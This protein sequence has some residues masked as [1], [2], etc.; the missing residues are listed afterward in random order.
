MNAKEAIIKLL[1]EKK[2]ENIELIDLK[3]SVY[4]VESVIVATI[5]SS[6]QA[7][8]IIDE[9]KEL[10]RTLGE[11]VL[12]EE[13]ADE[14]SV[15]DLGDCLIHLMS[16]LYRDKYQLEKFLISLKH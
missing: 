3:N 2:A 8:A 1:D 10:L 4:F 5:S 11:K 12:Y 6:K 14:W 16:P 7:I 13:R 15:L 9:L